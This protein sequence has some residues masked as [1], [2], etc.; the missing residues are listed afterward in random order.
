MVDLDAF[1]AYLM[2]H[3]PVPTPA[4]NRITRTVVP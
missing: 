2:H 3:D 1:V 4:M